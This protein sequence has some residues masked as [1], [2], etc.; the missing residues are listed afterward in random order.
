MTC[1]DAQLSNPFLKNRLSTPSVPSA[2][3][4]CFLNGLCLSR[5]SSILDDPYTDNLST[6]ENASEASRN[7]EGTCENNV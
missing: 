6:D 2:L 1:N 4:S 5:S 3:S 7:T